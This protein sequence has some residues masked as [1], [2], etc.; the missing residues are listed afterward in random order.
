MKPQVI[1]KNTKPVPTKLG[2]LI[3]RYNL[4]PPEQNLSS[5]SVKSV[6]AANWQDAGKRWSP[7]KKPS[8]QWT[9]E[10]R[11]SLSQK[12]EGLP[13]DFKNFIWG[14]AKSEDHPFM[15][16]VNADFDIAKFW[17]PTLQAIIRYEDFEHLRDQIQLIVNF[18]FK[19]PSWLKQFENS[20]RDN[21]TKQ[22]AFL[23]KHFEKE[24]LQN[25]NSPMP[26]LSF[27][28]IEIDENGILKTK[29]DEFSDA[30]NG[31]DIRRIRECEVCHRIYWAGRVEKFCCSKKCNL[32]L[33]TW[34][35]RNIYKS[36]QQRE[37]GNRAKREIR[38]YKSRKK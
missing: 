20:K 12:L 3:D 16:S 32:I 27:A 17:Y 2:I 22:F 29:L 23:K 14:D 10:A 13:E 34:L 26:F 6:D 35:N 30:V 18:A 15:E 36:E 4:L 1:H 25:E 28:R 31:V 9:D 5:L 24:K 7:Y 38:Y 11:W 19:H 33:N 8:E 21:P 37:E